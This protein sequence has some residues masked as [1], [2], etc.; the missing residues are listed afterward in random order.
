VLL[1]PYLY[2]CRVLLVSAPPPMQSRPPTRIPCASASSGLEQRRFERTQSVAGDHVKS[3]AKRD[4][5]S[6]GSADS[7]ME[8]TYAQSCE[9]SKYTECNPEN[10][11]ATLIFY[12]NPENFR[13]L[14]ETSVAAWFPRFHYAL[15][16]VSR[17]SIQ[18][19]CLFP[20][21]RSP[22][23]HHISGYGAQNA[24][25]PLLRTSTN[26]L[27]INNRRRLQP[28]NLL[29]AHK[30]PNRVAARLQQRSMSSSSVCG[31]KSAAPRFSI[32]CRSRLRKARSPWA[33]ASPRR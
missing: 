19:C 2:G 4:A 5:K 13:F 12:G 11:A 15:L 33:P 6:V 32:R 26:N 30:T 24:A 21:I 17:D 18:C 7:T 9:S 23:T 28:G 10:Q 25:P 29:F 31:A 27:S 3:D 14:W 1:K 22:H 16:L 20:K 8:R